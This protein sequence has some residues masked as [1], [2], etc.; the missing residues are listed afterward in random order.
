MRAAL[1]LTLFA[2]AA[3]SACAELRSATPA[4]AAEQPPVLQLGSD[5]RPGRYELALEIDPRQEGFRG[6][7]SIHV[8]LA[9]ERRSFWLHGQDLHVT[10]AEIEAA[11]QRGPA[12]WEQVNDEGLARLT[13]EKAVPASRSTSARFSASMEP[14]RQPVM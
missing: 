6:T 3:T 10:S 7:A 1:A 14:I 12:R 8:E 5:V 2:L 13:A 4:A 9:H 11:G